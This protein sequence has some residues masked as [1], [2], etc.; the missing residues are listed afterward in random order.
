MENPGWSET[1]R[2]NLRRVMRD[3]HTAT[4]SSDI[5]QVE[6]FPALFRFSIRSSCAASSILATRKSCGVETLEPRAP[7]GNKTAEKT[8]QTVCTRNR[9][10]TLYCSCLSRNDV[11]S[12]VVWCPLLLRNQGTYHVF[13]SRTEGTHSRLVH[14]RPTADSSMK[15]V[16]ETSTLYCQKNFFTW[17]IPANPHRER[18]LWLRRKR[19]MRAHRRRS[20]SCV[21]L[22][23]LA[24]RSSL[25]TKLPRDGLEGLSCSGWAAN[26]RS[27]H[28]S[29]SLDDGLE[30]MA[31]SAS[32]T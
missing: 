30:E 20:P 31:A 23:P 21:P 18:A 12:K 11:F 26:A 14:K 17:Q 32:S 9:K 7:R 8:Y 3:C 5:D 15:D 4:F 24:N 1:N 13:A 28:C 16:D 2:W 29:T 27:N 19:M 22:V 25:T 10:D 6:L